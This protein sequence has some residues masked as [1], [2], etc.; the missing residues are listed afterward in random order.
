VYFPPPPSLLPGIVLQITSPPPPPP[1][2]NVQT[3]TAS[4]FRQPLV[5]CLNYTHICPASALPRD[6]S[7][8]ATNFNTA[9]PACCTLSAAACA[10]RCDATPGCLAFKYAW[11]VSQGPAT[12]AFANSLLTRLAACP[13][14][15]EHA[16]HRNGHAHRGA[17]GAAV[18]VVRAH[19]LL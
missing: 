6:P 17:R 11:R 1:P 3:V 12:L 18:D 14:V 4:Y 15:D 10:A 7:C 13:Q 5:N 2:I 9:A 16:A 19:G 8:S